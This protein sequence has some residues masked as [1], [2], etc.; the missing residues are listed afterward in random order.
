MFFPGPCSPIYA[1]A[2]GLTAGQKHFQEPGT[3]N[4]H[5]RK[6]STQAQAPTPVSSKQILLLG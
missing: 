4:R 3:G 1:G 6:R 2:Q 5:D